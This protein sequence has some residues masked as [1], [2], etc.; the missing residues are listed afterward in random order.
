M[1]WNIKR[2]DPQSHDSY[3]TYD[4]AYFGK[5]LSERGG[6]KYDLPASARNL[7]DRMV[8]MQ[9]A[10]SNLHSEATSALHHE[11]NEWLQGQHEA[12]R[13]A[14][15]Y[16]NKRKGVVERRQIMNG[17]VGPR[18]DW[19]PTWWGNGQLTHLDGVRDYLRESKMASEKQI[20]DLNTL[21]EFGPRNL[22]Q[23]WTYFKTWV[24]GMPP[25]EA[26]P[27]APPGPPVYSRSRGGPMADE[28]FT[29]YD[30]INN[31]YGGGGSGGGGGGDG[32]G[33]D[34]GGGGGRAGPRFT[35]GGRLGGKAVAAAVAK[36]EP[37]PPPPP[38]ATGGAGSSSDPLPSPPRPTLSAPSPAPPAGALRRVS[39]R[40]LGLAPNE[41]AG[42]A[43]IST[44]AA[45]SEL[46]TS[47]PVA[48]V[49]V[50]TTEGKTQTETTKMYNTVS[51][52]DKTVMSQSDTQ[53]ENTTMTDFKVQVDQ[54]VEYV[55][56][57]DVRRSTAQIDTQTD[58]ASMTSTAVQVDDRQVET[59]RELYQLLAATMTAGVQSLQNALVDADA[60]V[61]LL[62][63]DADRESDDMAFILNEIRH[64]E[65]D[66]ES[67]KK[68]KQVLSDE[69]QLVE[70]QAESDMMQY[71]AELNRLARELASE[72]AN[73]AV[74]SETITDLTK[75]VD[76][77]NHSIQALR[78]NVRNQ[79]LVVMQK[80]IAEQ[81]YKTEMKKLEQETAAADD[82]Y[83]QALWDKSGQ[84]SALKAALQERDTRLRQ[85]QDEMSR[86]TEQFQARMQEIT[87]LQ[88]QLK[89][90]R[91]TAR[92]FEL[93]IRKLQDELLEN[94]ADYRNTLIDQRAKRQ[95][96]NLKN[97][98]LKQQLLE[99]NKKASQLL[100]ENNRLMLADRMKRRKS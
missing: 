91:E 4:M 79:R 52:T 24:K 3:P 57:E 33:G 63:D 19:N 39:R 97:I 37:P 6:T 62:I 58:S 34:G 68:M 83:R 32:G 30:P 80:A 99:A 18:H 84:E 53:T 77:A 90:S 73:S 35:G 15:R 26:V 94:G 40:V 88:G 50:K 76:E 93:E 71:A 38:Q 2:N 10:A 61:E 82:L 46:L 5:A 47:P 20:I 14:R 54:P 49:Q 7:E 89:T 9:H 23:A 25:D 43:A 48:A 44:T 21:A 36:L 60:D 45:R 22:E 16:D 85:L 86:L 69:L 1:V 55:Q 81:V 70:A 95:S 27:F 56:I 87:V 92:Y 66:T 41:D 96:T 51:Q 13:V 31:A 75:Q 42:D 100:Q 59:A 65:I 11:F 29:L 8:Y 74:K 12:N 28:N 64:M 17:E 98:K 78:E 72:R 67:L